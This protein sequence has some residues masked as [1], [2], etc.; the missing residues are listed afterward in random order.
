M[1]LA[2]KE[3]DLLRAGAFKKKERK[4]ETENEGFRGVFPALLKVV[5]FP[6]LTLRATSLLPLLI[7]TLPSTLS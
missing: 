3:K 5:I 6:M 7:A 1:A 2:G 4:K